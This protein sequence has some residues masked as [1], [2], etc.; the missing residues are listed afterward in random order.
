MNNLQT[1]KKYLVYFLLLVLLN[2]LYLFTNRLNMQIYSVKIFL[3]NYIP[4]V[5]HMIIPYVIWYPY[6]W[7]VLIYLFIKD[8]QLFIAHSKTI[9]LS[10]A[11]CILIYIVFPTYVV[12]PEIQ[13]VDIFS[14]LVLLIYSQDNPVNVFPSIHVLN[15]ILAHIAILNIK[16]VKNYIK[17]ISWIYSLL[18][19]LSTVMTKQHYFLDII[20]GYVL[21]VGIAKLVY[22]KTYESYTLSTMK[23]LL[24]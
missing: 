17:V 1:G 21:A 16:G 11:I 19:I 2:F 10:K 22:N 13:G 18:V 4:F 12:R 24:Q 15:T 6:V 5:K 7:G 9:I 20:G 8:K 14:K 3:D 23:A